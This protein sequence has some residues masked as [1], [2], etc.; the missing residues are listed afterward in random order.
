MKYVDVFYTDF[1]GKS[2]DEKRVYLNTEKCI[3]Y[4]IDSDVNIEDLFKIFELCASQG[5]IDRQSIP[6]NFWKD[7]L[8]EKN[9]FYF[10]P[11][12]QLT[13]EVVIFDYETN[14]LQE[15][16][17]YREIKIKFTKQDLLE[18]AYSKLNMNKIFFQEDN[19]LAQLD[20][21]YKKYSKAF[22]KNNIHCNVL[23]YI[24]YL[25]DISHDIHL[26]TQKLLNIQDFEADALEK[27]LSIIEIAKIKH[28]D[29]IIER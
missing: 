11:Y 27:L 10:H 28:Y 19:D 3:N 5:Y 17:E 15:Q 29:Q 13:N 20:Y 6:L 16:N 25:I 7:N 9:K 4:I 23:D 12:L 24:L 22:A 26:K 1:V 2:P 18:Y 8:I 14:A 21:M